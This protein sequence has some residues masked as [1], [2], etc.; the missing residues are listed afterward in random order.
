MATVFLARLLGV[1][2]FQRLVAIK[3]LHPHLAREEEFVEMFLDEARLAARI[4][5]PNV[6]PIQEV[7]QSE[8][9]YYLV[10]DYIEGD[11][12]AR[13]LARSA[14][15]RAHVRIDVVTRVVLDVLAG[16]HAAHEMVD[17]AG[18]PL[19][20]VHR[21]VSP[22]NILVG[23]DGV[24]RITDFG[25][26]RAASRLSTTRS[27]QL[28]GKL[29]YMAPEQAR[30]AGVD[31]RADIFACGIVLWEA[32]AVKR[33]FKGD[34]EAETLNRVLYEPIPMLRSAAPDVPVELERVT[35]KALERDPAAR[36]ATAQEFADDL[37][38]A[39]RSA[40]GISSV[41]DVAAC[42]EEVIGD[43]LEQHRE[44]V[45]GWLARSEPS[46]N[47][48]PRP[49]DIPTKVEGSKP[50]RPPESRPSVDRLVDTI[51]DTSDAQALLRPQGDKV[52]SVS[53][54][55]IGVGP[56]GPDA[57]SRPSRARWAVVGALLALVFGVAGIVGWRAV[58]QARSATV[59]PPPTSAPAVTAPPPPSATAVSVADAVEAPDAGPATT[60]AAPT[61]VK[62]PPGRPK[63]SPG[64]PKP[65][66]KPT[67]TA[68][69]D[70]ISKNPYR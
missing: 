32:L 37:E 62:P 17:D 40:R 50:S 23:V 4:H 41:R 35:M 44:A 47:S 24:A 18:A 61:P 38:R 14:A 10:M 42:V 54:A 27:G 59:P 30:G 66:V 25:V 65:G 3:R 22:Q 21:D 2:G 16:L 49:V 15:R 6:V 45:R 31:R 56:L 13:L 20:I 19:S 48:R 9:G 29:A 63:P 28:K 43:E 39:A 26:A 51:S 33:L 1:A 58:G 8:R 60:A 70:D 52:S 5:H 69:P 67:A 11:T 12:L 55:V 46:A 53:S 68:V 64:R 36:Y 7:G 34:G 57:T